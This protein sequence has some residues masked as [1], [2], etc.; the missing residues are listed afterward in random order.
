[1]QRGGEVIRKDLGPNNEE[2]GEEEQEEMEVQDEKNQ[3][4]LI[5]TMK[6]IWKKIKPNF[7]ATQKNES[8][9]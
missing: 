9:E 8:E 3:S 5:S 6:S 1:M 7:G 4:K 2:E